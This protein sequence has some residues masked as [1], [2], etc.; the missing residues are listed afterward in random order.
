MGSMFAGL[1]QC[2]AQPYGMT[3]AARVVFYTVKAI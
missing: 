2:E 3:G 1:T